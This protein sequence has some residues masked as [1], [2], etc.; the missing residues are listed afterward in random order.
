VELYGKS[1]AGNSCGGAEPARVAR[2]FGLP[3]KTVRKM[4]AYPAPPGNQ[5]QKPVRRP[6]L[7]RG[8]LPSRRFWTKTRVATKAASHREADL[9]AITRRARVYGG[10]TIRKGLRA[11][12]EAQADFGETLVVVAEL[13]REAHCLPTI[14]VRIGK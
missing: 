8:R 9:R 5:R 14:P 2:E 1:A 12:G 10:L 11:P 6:K 4:L 7:D 13:E 3:R